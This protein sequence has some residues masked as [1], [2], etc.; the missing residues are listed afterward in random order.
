MG[1]NTFSGLFQVAFSNILY[2][3]K[4]LEKARDKLLGQIN[5]VSLT[6]H[7]KLSK[8][9]EKTYNSGAWVALAGLYRAG[10]K[11]FEKMSMN[12]SQGEGK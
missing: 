3:D 11:S 6:F 4:I 5:F 1:I 12:D 7:T 8:Q 9:M 2:L 10:L